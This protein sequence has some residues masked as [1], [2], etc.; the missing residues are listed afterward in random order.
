MSIRD[1]LGVRHALARPTGTYGNGCQ[2]AP[3]PWGNE[4]VVLAQYAV[5]IIKLMKIF[6]KRLQINSHHVWV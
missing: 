6:G 5:F 2:R 3:F 4:A 1:S